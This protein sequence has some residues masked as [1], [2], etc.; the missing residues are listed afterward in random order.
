MVGGSVAKLGL[1]GIPLFKEK[2]LC[3]D[4]G[5]SG[6]RVS[7][8]KL[9]FFDNFMPCGDLELYFLRERNVDGLI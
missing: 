7:L 9:S 8:G 1:I 4:M 3:L 6:I 2:A 5:W